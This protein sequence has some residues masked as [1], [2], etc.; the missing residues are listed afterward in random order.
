MVGLMG[1]AGAGMAAAQAPG[2]VTM[3]SLDGWRFVSPTPAA[4]ADVAVVRQD[5]IV[6]MAGSPVG[7]LATNA[8]FRD[9]QLHAEWRWTGKPGNGGA[10]I[11][12]AGTP[13][14]GAWPVCYQVQ[15]KNTAVGDLLPMVGATFAEPLTTAP[16]AKTPARA[17]QAADT[18]RPV[19]DWNVMDVVSK[20]GTIEVTVNGVVQ[21]RISG[22]S[23][24]DGAVGFQF[25]G[26]P[27]EMRAVSVTPLAAAPTR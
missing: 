4:L 10:L 22:L 21:N 2:R 26:T 16:D 17:H 8:T 25:E 12:I 20:G 24:H 23:Q 18:E 5:G 14:S 13:A 19:G 3:A 7:Y 15:M 9:F 11:H 27:F 1:L 6:A